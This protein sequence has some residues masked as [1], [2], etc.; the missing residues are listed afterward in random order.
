MKIT[1]TTILP[2]MMSA[3]VMRCWRSS[4]LRC[5]AVSFFFP[6]CVAGDLCGALVLWGFFLGVDMM[7]LLLF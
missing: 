1:A 3:C 2:M 4:S 6:L 5:A 7:G